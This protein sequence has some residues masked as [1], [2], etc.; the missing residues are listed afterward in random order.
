MTSGRTRVFAILGQPVAHSLSP[1]MHQAAFRVLGLEAVYVPIPC[2][3]EQVPVLIE[4]L[5]R[6]GGGGNV[7]VPHKEAAAEAVS[8]PSERVRRL[9]ACNTFWSAGAD[10]ATMGDNTD[11]DGIGEALDRLEAPVTRWLVL[12]T[13]GSARAVAEAARERGAALAVRSRSAERAAAFLAW[14]GRLGVRSADEAEAEVVINATPVGLAGDA[15]WPIRFESV[16]AARAALD[17]VYAPGETAWIREARRRGLAAADGRS[18]LLAQGVEA[19]RRWL[20]KVSPP[21]E[22]MRAALDAALRG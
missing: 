4:V 11:V 18:V 1:V 14:S 19:F 15:E 16:P 12:G 6:A 5:C 7:T 3:A 10:G 9:G 8:C 20:P 21:R 17:L 22:V 2:S 13:G